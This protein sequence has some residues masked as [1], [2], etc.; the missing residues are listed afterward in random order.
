MVKP[1]R[2]KR[3]KAVQNL[4]ANAIN[5]ANFLRLGI[6]RC[7]SCG[8]DYGL[9][10]AH[11]KKRRHYRTLEELTDYNEVILLCLR[12][13]EEIEKSPQKT[14]ELFKRLRPKNS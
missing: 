14:I 11:R 2:D 10:F 7:E 5:K 13:H 12:E 6:T 1:E 4:E 3:P 9:S 8:T